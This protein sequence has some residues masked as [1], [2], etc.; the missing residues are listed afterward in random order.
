MSEF[1]PMSYE[2]IE[3]GT[4]YQ[5]P[6]YEVV[7]GKGIQLTGNHTQVQFVRG[8]KLREETVERKEG[9]LHESLLSMMIED[10]QFKYDI[11]PAEE[12]ERALLHLKSALDALNAR[13]YKRKIAG[14]LGTY[15][16]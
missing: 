14:T 3:E 11:V 5:L 4:T 15:K 9:I 8:S 10:L 6:N 7:D 16:K 2:T 1:N 13:A 12:T